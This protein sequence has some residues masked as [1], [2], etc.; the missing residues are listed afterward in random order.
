MISEH[1]GTVQ[2]NCLVTFLAPLKN[3]MHKFIH[4]P[5][6]SHNCIGMLLL[7]PASQV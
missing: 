4:R 3:L 7:R 2:V 5:N 6:G 1:G